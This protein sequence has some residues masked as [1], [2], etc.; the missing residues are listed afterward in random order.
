MQPCDGGSYVAAIDV[1]GKVINRVADT[2]FQLC[3]AGVLR[4]AL[5]AQPRLP[6]VF[7]PRHGLIAAGA[8]RHHVHHFSLVL[9]FTVVNDPED[10]TD[11][12]GEDYPA[13][14]DCGHQVSLET[15]N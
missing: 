2:C 8:R 12:Y 11:N 6:V 15:R 10:E 5:W 14:H 9:L 1:E 7:S 13:E 3:D 4:C